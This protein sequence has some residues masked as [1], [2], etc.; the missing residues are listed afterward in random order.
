MTISDEIVLTI[1]DVIVLTS[2]GFYSSKEEKAVLKH[3]ISAE[4]RMHQTCLYW[5]RPSHI[6]PICE[7]DP[8]RK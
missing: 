2:A 1:S 3:D 5:R 4:Y 6:F 7:T 8:V